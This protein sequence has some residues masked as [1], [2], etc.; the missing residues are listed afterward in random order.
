MNALRLSASRWAD[1][2]T[3]TS[4]AW[5]RRDH[6]D[7]QIVRIEEWDCFSVE[8]RHH[9]IRAG[10]YETG[11]AMVTAEMRL[12]GEVLDTR[13]GRPRSNMSVRLNIE[14]ASEQRVDAEGYEP[15][16]EDR[17]GG[18]PEG[19]DLGASY[20]GHIHVLL[21]VE[22]RA[23]ISVNVNLH[24]PLNLVQ[25]LVAMKDE[26]IRF[27]TIHDS[28]VNPRVELN[29]YIAGYV[30]RCSFEPIRSL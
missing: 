18:I 10:F 20:I 25:L 8:V 6:M 5:N 28:V 3:M 17:P 4:G 30:K 27:S 21:P 2:D 22:T 15:R 24:L 19:Y 23:N 1:L 16:D 14:F 12:E 13:S 26:R 11:E 9:A 7:A 29:S